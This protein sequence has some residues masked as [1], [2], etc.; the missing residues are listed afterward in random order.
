MPRPP[1]DFGFVAEYQF[2]RWIFL[3][4]VESA[5]K[6]FLLILSISLQTFVGSMVHCITW[7]GMAVV[8]ALIRVMRP[9]RERE[10]AFQSRAELIGDEVK[11]SGVSLV[12]EDRN[13]KVLN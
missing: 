7:V 12:C 6:N 5:H 13:S 9:A 4:V 10:L 2:R 11:S 3:L 8:T 1:K